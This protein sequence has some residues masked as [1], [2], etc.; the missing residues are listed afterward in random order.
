MNADDL[1]FLHEKAYLEQT[2]SLLHRTMLDLFD[3]RDEEKKKLAQARE[4]LIENQPA[5]AGDPDNQN[6]TSHYLTELE[7]QLAVYQL[8]QER[9][10]RYSRLQ[11]SPISGG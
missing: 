10:E 7:N 4:N 1:D 9:L 8:Y 5:S 2:K 11:D 6:D 3:L